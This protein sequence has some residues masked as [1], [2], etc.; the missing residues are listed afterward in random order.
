MGAVIADTHAIIWYLL[1]SPELS[2]QAATAL[3]DA[4]ASGDGI[5]VASISV[6]E[7]VYLVEKGR[8][9]ALA[10]DRLSSSMSA[11]NSGLLIAPLDLAVATV[12]PRIPREAVPDMP[13]RI[14]AATALHLNLP[15]VSRDHKIRTAGIETIW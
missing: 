15:L 5:Y 3:D 7:I 10:F 11:H 1:A 6:I 2:S 14:I 13:D 12:V 9:P 8:I 4:V